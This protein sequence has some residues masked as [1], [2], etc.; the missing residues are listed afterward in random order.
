MPNMIKPI[1]L[2]PS[3][4]PPTMSMRS[5]F[6]KGSGAMYLLTESMNIEK[7][8][9]RRKTAFTSEP[10]I[11]ARTHPKVLCDEPDFF[12]ILTATR[13]IMSERQ[14]LNMWNASASR[15]LELVS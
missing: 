13:P 9:A 8:S 14:S 4:T 2:I 11:S 7:Q 15:E 10:R 6:S 5:T 3:P 1:R 12:D